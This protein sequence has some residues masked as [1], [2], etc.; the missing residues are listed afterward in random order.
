MRTLY[1][2][3]IGISL[4]LL[5]SCKEDVEKPK[6]IYD[7]SKGVKEPAKVDTTQIKIADL[8][9]QMEGTNYLIHPVGDLS[10]YEKGAKTK[11]GSSSVNDLSFTISNESENEITG[12]LQNLKFQKIG[13]DSIKALTDKPVLIQTAT[14]L[15][16]V[17]DK[18][19]KQIMVYA[20]MDMD[21]NKD[22]KLDVSDITTLYL[23]EISGEKL[24]KVSAD[25]QELIDWNLIESQNRLYFRTVEDTNKNGRFDSNDVVHYNYIDLTSKDWKAES[26]NPI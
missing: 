21:T 18:L 24:T 9:I 26:Y 1:F 3:C 6:V 12:Y 11:Y 25:Y 7:A 13:S 10:V 15:K 5:A 20:M 23:S 22:G 14:Y 4:L 8:P 17:S 2:A 16:K 19:K